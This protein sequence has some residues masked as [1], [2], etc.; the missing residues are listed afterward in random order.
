MSAKPI[1]PTFR[2]HD[3]TAKAKGIV[4]AD[5]IPRLKPTYLFRNNSFYVPENVELYK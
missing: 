2:E 5:R 1:T 4:G 3:F